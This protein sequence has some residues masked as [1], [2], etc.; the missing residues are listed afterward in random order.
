MLYI[1]ALSYLLVLALYTSSILSALVHYPL[2][3][4]L[5]YLYVNVLNYNYML[6]YNALIDRYD[7]LLFATDEMSR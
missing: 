7:S 6:K 5:V 1:P 2:C 4:I 3:Y